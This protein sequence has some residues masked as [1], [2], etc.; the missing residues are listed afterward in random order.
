MGGCGEHA[1]AAWMSL[2]MQCR[3]R[4]LPVPVPQ[5]CVRN[6]DSGSR[7]ADPVV[8]KPGTESHARS[9]DY[10]RASFHCRITLLFLYREGRSLLIPAKMVAPLGK[11]PGLLEMSSLTHTKGSLVLRGCRRGQILPN[12][13]WQDP[14]GPL[15]LAITCTGRAKR[16]IRAAALLPA[17]PAD[18][19]PAAR[20]T[21][22]EPT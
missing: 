20:T 21:H 12:Q 9:R 1:P 7:F 5:A 18:A 15:T 3:C 6:A 2:C 10:Y 13:R 4:T 14:V 8:P 22:N 11:E 19:G 16:N 17:R